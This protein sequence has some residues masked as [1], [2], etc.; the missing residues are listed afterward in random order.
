MVTAQFLRRSGEIT[1]M[2]IGIALA[3]SV[4]VSP[5][6]K[7]SIFDGSLDRRKPAPGLDF[8]NS[9]IC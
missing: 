2:E 9:K 6:D 1:V 5:F 3:A 7:K 8:N 4:S